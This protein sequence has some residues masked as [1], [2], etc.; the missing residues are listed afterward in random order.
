M[1]HNP[2]IDKSDPQI[3]E[4]LYKEY[5]D[6]LTTLQGCYVTAEDVG[7]HVSDM[8]NVFSQTRFTTCIPESLGGSGNP[9][10]PTARGV[11]SGMEAA[12]HF[13]G[14]GTL[15]DKTVAV[16]GMG[17]VGEP[18]IRFLFESGVKKVI[19]AD[20][21]SLLVEKV[22]NSFKDKNLE[23]K[24][25]SPGDLS[26]LHTEC[27]ILA[28]CATGAAL[29]PQTIPGI[30]AKIICGAANNQ[31]A[32]SEGDDRLLFDKG[33]IYVPDFLT[34][35]MGIVN[36]ANEQYGYV[37][38]DEFIERHLK[39]D[40]EYSVYKTAL[41]VLTES[42]KNKKPTARVAIE[43]ADVLSLQEHPVFGHRGFRIIQSLVENR[44]HEQA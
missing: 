20:I 28:P 27:D 4:D 36:C 12:L 7:T 30:K 22:K 18:L 16:Q 6:F 43:M 13:A 19:A 41:K 40:W 33:I 32:D 21:N 25:V 44:W 2:G 39:T 35:R 15:Q 23:A 14:M 34:N 1:S 38:N 9:S 11:I 3:R 37:N 10:V 24:A 8:A 26:I 5:G 42:K 29:N 31:L 17:N